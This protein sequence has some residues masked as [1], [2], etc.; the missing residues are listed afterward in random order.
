MVFSSLV[1]SHKGHCALLGIPEIDPFEAGVL[2]VHLIESRL[3]PIE[4]Q[5]ILH[6]CLKPAVRLVAKKMPVK[7]AIVVP[8]TPLAEVVSHEEKL[9][10]G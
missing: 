8:L 2:E 10:S 1:L 5:K 3:I 6:K 7:T 4:A 9:L